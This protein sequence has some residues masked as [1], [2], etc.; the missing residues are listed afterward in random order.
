M[1]ELTFKYSLCSIERIAN[2]VTSPGG[3]VV[4]NV[5]EV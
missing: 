1:P 3:D 5:V 4:T 2:H